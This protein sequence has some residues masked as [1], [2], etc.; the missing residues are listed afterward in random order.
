MNLLKAY[1]E[2]EQ[3]LCRRDQ[4]PEFIRGSKLYAASRYKGEVKE[5]IVRC[6]K[7]HFN[8]L[9][10]LERVWIDRIIDHWIPFFK[11]HKIHDIVP[12][13]SNPWRV[14]IQSSLSDYMAERIARALCVPVNRR[15]LQRRF[16]ENG[17]VDKLSLIHI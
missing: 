10:H 12:V 11:E 6:K 17:Q 4:W 8:A 14:L 1:R 7:S 13:P 3:H 9:P 15:L 2:L 5:L 16:F